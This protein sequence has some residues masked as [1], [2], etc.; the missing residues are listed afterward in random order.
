MDLRRILGRSVKRCRELN[1]RLSSLLR[2]ARLN[3]TTQ[4][5]VL[6]YV[7]AVADETFPQKASKISLHLRRRQPEVLKEV[8]LGYDVTYEDLPLRSS[9]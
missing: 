4:I 7:S 2:E 6:E 3:C 9:Y 1:T 8:W 5:A